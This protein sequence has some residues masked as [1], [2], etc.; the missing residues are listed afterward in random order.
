MIYLKIIAMIWSSFLMYNFQLSLA[1]LNY[2]VG[3]QKDF[4]ISSF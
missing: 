3:R 2:F 4:Q 1:A